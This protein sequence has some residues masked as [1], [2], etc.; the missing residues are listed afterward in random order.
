MVGEIRWLGHK[1]IAANAPIVTL[2]YWQGS[3]TGIYAYLCTR[4]M[5]TT[6]RIETVHPA[7]EHDHGPTHGNKNRF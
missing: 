1:L 4:Q 6:P 7:I 2:L 3:T 5:A